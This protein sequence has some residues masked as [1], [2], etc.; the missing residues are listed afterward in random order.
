MLYCNII[1]QIF[2]Y[3]ICTLHIL[4]F[5]INQPGSE[6]RPTISNFNFYS[7]C[8]FELLLHRL[9]FKEVV[10]MSNFK[11]YA[12]AILIPV[13]VGGIVGLI[14][15][16]SIDYNSLKQPPLSPPSILFPI[17]WSI[18]YILMGISYGILD[19]NL[20]VDSGINSIYYLQLFV[21]ALWSIFFFVFKWR[22]FSFLWI[23]LLLALVVIMIVRFYR[24]NK[25][26]GLLQIPYLLW[27]LFATYLN[28]GVYLLNK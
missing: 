20:L 13:V 12:K 3:V 24:K 2:Q 11:I 4:L 27:I 10:L 1:L 17:V 15:S 22:F 7:K 5:L 6:L 26:S 8:I 23:L 18:L 16:S 9:Y 14:I 21:N 25:A 28:L 19:S